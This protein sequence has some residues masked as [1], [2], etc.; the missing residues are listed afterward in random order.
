MQSENVL[1]RIW[2]PTIRKVQFCRKN[3]FKPLE[4]NNELPSITTLVEQ[5]SRQRSIIDE[6]GSVTECIDEQMSTCYFLH[7]S[8]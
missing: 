2:V 3:E 7:Q 8:Q 5:L 4:D 1:Y 6:D